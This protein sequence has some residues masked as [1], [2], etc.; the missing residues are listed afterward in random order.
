MHRLYKGKSN[1]VKV[2]HDSIAVFLGQFPEFLHRAAG[3]TLRVAVPHDGLDDGLC[4][5]VMQT[6]AATCADG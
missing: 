5:A 4:A 1:R 6:V 3:I 2:F